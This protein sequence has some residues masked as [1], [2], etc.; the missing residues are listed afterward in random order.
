MTKALNQVFKDNALVGYSMPKWSPDLNHLA[1]AD[2]TVIFSSC[3][4]YAIEK[5]MQ[6]LKEY[7]AESGKKINVEKSFFCMH[8]NTSQT[9]V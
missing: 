7:E 6:V 1:Y 5:I 3:N 9:I 2:D 8:K 4:K